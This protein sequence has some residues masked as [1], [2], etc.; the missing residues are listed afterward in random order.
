[1]L[2]LPQR[3]PSLFDAAHT[4]YPGRPRLKRCVRATARQVGLPDPAVR[5]MI[6]PVRTVI[7]LAN[8]ISKICGT[9][10]L[11]FLPSRLEWWQ[12]S[13]ANKKTIK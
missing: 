8:Y 13:Y 4:R 12:S 7:S 11:P 2:K 1:M 9:V 5:P 10:F 3:V 6:D